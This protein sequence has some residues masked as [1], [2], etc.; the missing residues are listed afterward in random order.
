QIF[1]Y[2]KGSLSDLRRGHGQKV[3]NHFVSEYD[4]SGCVIR[5]E[6]HQ[7]ENDKLIYTEQFRYAGDPPTIERRVVLPDGK[8]KRPAKYR[9]DG[10][11]RVAEMWGEDGYHVHWKY[12]TQGR[13]TEQLTEAYAVPDGCD[14]CPIPGNIETRYE[15]SAREQTFFS[16]SGKPLLRRI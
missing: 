12:D 1:K 3:E 8:S 11:D 5:R 14:E 6:I 10:A 4:G 13:V 9:L 7:G 2:E 16:P 15:R